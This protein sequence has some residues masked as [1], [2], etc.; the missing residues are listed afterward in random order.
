MN[1]KN[2]HSFVIV[3]ADSIYKIWEKEN[4]QKITSV[5]GRSTVKIDNDSVCIKIEESVYCGCQKGVFFECFPRYFQKLVS[6]DL[7]FFGQN[8][9]IDENFKNYYF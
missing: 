2:H 4:G 3:L 6:F 9:T 5:M 1:T 8:Y 7:A